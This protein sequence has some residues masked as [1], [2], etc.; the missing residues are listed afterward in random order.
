LTGVKAAAS[1]RDRT[2]LSRLSGISSLMGSGFA[3]SVGGAHYLAVQADMDRQEHRQQRTS[4]E[5]RADRTRIHAERKAIKW[6][7][8]VVKLGVAHRERPGDVE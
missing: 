3:G 2:L 8:E 5:E 4:A 7:Q 6:D 1:T